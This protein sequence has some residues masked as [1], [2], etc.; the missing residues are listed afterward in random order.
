MPEAVLIL[1]GARTA[2]I[3]V[4]RAEGEEVRPSV[5]LAEVRPVIEEM[6]HA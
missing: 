4:I 2:S 6:L 3:T 5:P 1:E